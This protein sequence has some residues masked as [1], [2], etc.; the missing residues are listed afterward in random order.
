MASTA[1]RTAVTN[2]RVFDG[3]RLRPPDTVVIEPGRRADL[4]LIDADPLQD[5]TATRSIRRV[6]CGGAQVQPSHQFALRRPR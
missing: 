5:I 3:R 4:V 6:W 2:V 1:P